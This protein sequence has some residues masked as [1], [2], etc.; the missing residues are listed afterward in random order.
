MSD[1][2]FV[3][4]FCA[5]SWLCVVLVIASYAGLLPAGQWQGDD[6]VWAWMVDQ[7]KWSMYL[8]GLWWAPRPIPQS[9][10]AI[11][12]LLSDH[13]HRPYIR[14]FLSVIWVLGVTLIAFVGKISNFPRPVFAACA[15]FALTLLISVPAEMFYWTSAAATYVPLWA[16]LASA[17][18]LQ[19]VPN[20]RGM[21]ALVACLM[22]A[23]LS[24]EIGAV[25]TLLY[26]TI[27]AITAL[28]TSK[29][30]NLQWALL[31]PA[32]CATIVCFMVLRG[33]VAPMQEGM[34]TTSALAGHWLRS[35]AAAFPTF[36]SEI[37]GIPGVN[38]MIGLLGKSL[39][40]VSVSQFTRQPSQDKRLALT[41]A[42]ALLIAT[43]STIVLANHQ[44][45]VLC[46]DRHANLRQGM[47]LLAMASSASLLWSRRS[48]AET[49]A[50]VL[51][52]CLLFSLR[53][54]MILHDL[55]SL[56]AVMQSRQST[57]ASARTRGES[58][59]LTDPPVTEITGTP[60]VANGTYHRRDEQPWLDPLWTSGHWDTWAIMALFGKHQLVV[61][62]H[63]ERR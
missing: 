44:F 32:L 59:T 4:L 25:V 48:N 10:L 11:Y 29:R 40:F 14:A 30:S 18:L 50:L 43:Y 8:S 63:S 45:G 47:I 37:F 49:S 61:E 34:N 3:P 17:T 41:W 57:W 51:A 22:V 9:L 58:M 6:Y 1:V 42:A 26:S 38:P 24:S 2:R 52:I 36:V 20:L 16:A 56:P 39:L 13:F 23:T 31:A 54:S 60:H 53:L 35:I 27:S 12:F 55:H 28:H 46:C 62:S 15:L 21:S 7:R 33:R 19:Q 5:A